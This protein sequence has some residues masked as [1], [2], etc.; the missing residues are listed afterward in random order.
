MKKTIIPAAML[1]ASTW[2]IGLQAQEFKTF[3]LNTYYTPDI[4]RRGLDLYVEANQSNNK[5]D[6][7]SDSGHGAYTFNGAFNIVKNTRSCINTIYINLNSSGTTTSSTG[8]MITTVFKHKDF[9]VNATVGADFLFYNHSKQYLRVGTNL[10][11][12]HNYVYDKINRADTI[13][14]KVNQTTNKPVISLYAGVGLGRIEDVTEAQQAI[15]LLDAFQKNN[16]L[17]KDLSHDEIFRLAQEM[18]RIKNS[19]FLDARLRLMAEV[20]HVDSFF[21]TNHLLD[22]KG[23]AYFTTLYDIWVN[24]ANFQRLAGQKIELL[25]NGRFYSQRTTSNYVI[26][27]NISGINDNQSDYI[28]VGLGY[29]Y[30][31][32]FLQKWQHS[33]NADISYS[34]FKNKNSNWQVTD[35]PTKSKTDYNYN[36]C[37]LNASYRLGFYPNTRTNLYAYCSQTLL[38]RPEYTISTDSYQIDNK[39]QLHSQSN[40]S[41]GI[42]YFISPQIQLMANAQLL[43]YKLFS[44]LSGD[45]SVRNQHYH[46]LN[47]GFKYLLF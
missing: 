44:D 25:G 18:S 23:A 47:I 16:I 28:S 14:S 17:T 13:Q 35:N 9:D 6:D 21:V 20:S 38:Y 15:Y 45:T 7:N 32:P 5:V 22:N 33:A 26:P 3:N 27:K 8:D 41:A 34:Y 43:Y 1:F 37:Q 4:V 24:G 29:N 19:R 30:E 11:F 46:G 12:T 2:A 40:L 31:H 36:N 39:N 10:N 42:Y